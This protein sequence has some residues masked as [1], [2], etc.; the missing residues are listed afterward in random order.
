MLAFFCNICFVIGAIS[1]IVGF[2]LLIILGDKQDK[3]LDACMAITIISFLLGGVIYFAGYMSE[4]IEFKEPTIETNKTSLISVSNVNT[5]E[6]NIQA[7]GLDV[8]GYLKGGNSYQYYYQREDGGI[9]QGTIPVD[10]TVIYYIES[11]EKAYLETITTIRYYKD[12]LDH[13]RTS[14]EYSYKLYIPKGSICEYEF[15]V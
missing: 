14:E 11:G 3:K 9:V 4:P 7:G 6:G 8:Y 13:I 1:L 15:V 10:S 2:V 12:K 5:L